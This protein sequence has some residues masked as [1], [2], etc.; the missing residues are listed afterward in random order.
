MGLFEGSLNISNNNS[1]L[2]TQN[3][4]NNIN[5]AIN[6]KCGYNKTFNEKSFSS[7]SPNPKQIFT[8]NI[9]NM[10]PNSSGMINQSKEKIKNFSMLILKKDKMDNFDK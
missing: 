1:A 8:C 4:Q 6:A 3:K 2:S 9:K 7:G 5:K 10:N